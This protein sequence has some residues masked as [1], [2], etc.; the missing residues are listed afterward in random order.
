MSIEKFSG[1][2]DKL[3]WMTALGD[4]PGA[5]LYYDHQLL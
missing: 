3:T 2:S 5:F 1:Y 4:Q